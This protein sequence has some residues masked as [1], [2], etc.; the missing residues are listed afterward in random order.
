MSDNE[1]LKFTHL[2][3]H[4]EYSLLDGS[5]KISELVKRAKELGMESLAITDHGAMF[6]V[7]DFYKACKDEGIKPIIGCEVYVAPKSRFDKSSRESVSYY[8]LVLLAENMEGYQNLIKLVSLGY[9]EGFYYKPRVDEEILRKYHSGIIATSACLAGPVAKTLINGSYDMAKEIALEYLDIFGEGNFYLELQNHGIADQKIVNAGLIKMSQETGIPLICTNDVHYI[10]Q[11]DWEAHDVLLCIQTGK[12]INDENR[13]RYEGN[14]FH[15]KSALEMNKLFSYVPEAI[16]NT[17]KIAE[18]C[19]VEFT[20]H[21]LKL[22]QYDVPDGFTAEQ[23]LQKIT[24]DGFKKRYP[25]PSDE[26]IDR[27]EYEFN[28]IVKMG[29]VDY[30]LIVWDYI[31]F[32]KDNGIT[33]GPGRGSAAGSV[34]AYSL[35]ITTIDPIKYDLIF[36][37]FL[38]PDR[39]SMPDIDVDFS[40]ERR[41]EV[42]DYVTEKYGSDKVAQIITFGTMAARAA[43]KDVGR[44]LDVPYADADRISK[45]VPAELNM[46]IDKALGMNPELKNEYENDDDV[47]KLIDMSRKLEGLPRHASTHAAGVVI[48][49]KP[50]VDYVPLYV[51]DKGTSTQFTMN[52]LE[53]LGILKMDFLGLR[54][55]TVVENAVNEIKRTH[56]IDVDIDSLE[57]DDPK[58]Y[59]MIAQGKTE[60]VFQ[61]ES[62]GMKQFMKELKPTHFE[63]IIAGISLYRPGPMDFIPKYVRGKNSGEKIQYTSPEL[64]PIL[65]NTYGCIVYQEQV[66]QIV[67][68]LAGYSLGRSD[69]VRRAMSKKK[70][71]V[72]AEERKNFVYGIEGEVSGCL[73]K[74][75]PAKTA[76]KIFDEM[77]DFAKYA[78]NKSHAACYAVLTYQTA[79]LKTYYPVEFMAALMTSVMDNTAKVA[80]YIDTCKHMGIELLP[81]DINEGFGG[82]SVSG[83][84]IR[85]GL[86]AIKSVGLPAVKALVAEREKNGKYK[87]LT[88]FCSRLIGQEVNKRMVENLIYAGAFDSFGGTRRQYMSVY[89]SVMDGLAQSKKNNIEGQLN[90]FDM[91]S[92]SEEH[93]ASDDFPYAEEFPEKE[94]LSFEKIVLGIY[95]SGHPLLEFIDVLDKKVNVHCADFLESNI[96]DGLSEIYDGQKIKIGGFIADKSVK[97]TRNNAQ[98]AFIRLEDMTGSTE[99]IVFPKS[100][101]KFSKYLYEDR[102]II[103]EGR[104][105]ISEGE[106]PRIVCENIIPFEKLDENRKPISIGIVLEHGITLDNV[107]SILIKHHGG[108]PLYVN[109]K[110]NGM[111]YKA[112]PSNWLDVSD[113]LINKLADVLGKANVVV[114]YR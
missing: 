28:T 7:I 53:E 111:K 80:G 43:I 89:K 60:G 41:Q 1:Q 91:G 29:Y 52:T 18:R 49:G 22:P 88:D 95:I 3:V 114:K 24:F 56:D 47:K 35:D 33:V 46:T 36:E 64:E 63:D 75:I 61:M 6:G 31:K 16:E 110:S 92:E 38:N 68:D 106:A 113:E 109:D 58:V 104:A 103:V 13:M 34:V 9:T 77:T 86:A 14:C 81:P 71:K 67:R 105:A 55:L 57:Y 74:G 73:T 17:N 50:V 20:F 76:E 42:I 10:R 8:H 39:V 59:E 11:E 23:Y 26:L 82:F 72:M 87:G 93:D 30:F 65:K 62:G 32:A 70:T 99:I 66:M 78:F 15:L 44:A 45:M 79:W 54:T 101:D 102:V 37:R 85:F 12:T 96:E 90:L 112:E 4:T 2:H 48:C 84:K 97:F 100:F 94:R 83:N 27:L 107:K 98:M 25:N 108:I 40:D 21:E 69:L 19:N 5:A 51:S